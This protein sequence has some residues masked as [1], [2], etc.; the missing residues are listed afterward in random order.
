MSADDERLSKGVE[1][2]QR[3]FGQLA[4]GANLPGDFRPEETRE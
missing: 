1:V 4:N 2:A 3:L